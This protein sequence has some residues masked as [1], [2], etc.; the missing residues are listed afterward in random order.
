MN[1]PCQEKIPRKFCIAKKRHNPENVKYNRANDKGVECMETIRQIAEEI[2]VTKQAV[3]G[4]AFLIPH[5]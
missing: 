3:R 5:Q 1:H 4:N 2:G